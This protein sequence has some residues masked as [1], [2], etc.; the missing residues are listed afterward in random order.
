MDLLHKERLSVGARLMKRLRRREG[1][2][3]PQH[4]ES[5]GIL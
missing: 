5:Q 4:P 1:L 2:L 3:V